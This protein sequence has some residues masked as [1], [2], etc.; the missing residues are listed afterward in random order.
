MSTSSFELHAKVAEEIDLEM[1]SYM[2]NC[3]MFKWSVTL[4]LTLDLVKVT[5]SYTVRP[6]LAMFNPPHTKFEV[7]AQARDCSITHYRNMAI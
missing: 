3:R 1:C 2:G 7:H 4:T 5:S 6:E